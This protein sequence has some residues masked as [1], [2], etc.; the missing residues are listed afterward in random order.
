V[1][2][3]VS[4]FVYGITT[5][6]EYNVY[7]AEHRKRSGKIFLDASGVQKLD[8]HFSVILA[9]VGSAQIYAQLIDHFP[10]NAQV[11]ENQ[12][13]RRPDLRMTS[14]TESG[15][16]SLTV[17]LWAYRGNIVETPTW[18]DEDPGLWPMTLLLGPGCT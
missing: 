2:T 1:S 12:E 16:S 5:R 11:P 15:A 8:E 9:K 14:L 13:F 17:T 10:Q 6:Q 18:I 3:R 7:N 4:R